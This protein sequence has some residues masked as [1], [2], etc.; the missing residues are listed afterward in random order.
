M[1]NLR[2]GTSSFCPTLILNPSATRSH[3]L[4]Q[5]GRSHFYLGWH[6]RECDRSCD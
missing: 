5:T 1:D 6:S 2:T 3:P 4:S